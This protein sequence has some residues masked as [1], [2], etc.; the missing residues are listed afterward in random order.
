M[1]VGRGWN[2]A[3]VAIV[4][5]GL[6]GVIALTAELRYG[7]RDTPKVA[8]VAG[9]VLDGYTPFGGVALL[10]IPAGRTWAGTLS[11]EGSL[12]NAGGSA[13]IDAAAIISTTGDGVIPAAGPLL[14]LRLSVANSSAGSPGNQSVG[15]VIQPFTVFATG[16]GPV[17][18][19]TFASN[20]T[21][22][23]FAA[24]GALL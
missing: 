2:R 24:S 19:T 10:T 20:L 3:I 12:R 6:V 7:K 16:H 15:Q 11:I 5:I 14:D 18:L 13:A 22:V 21:Q 17:T 8:P 9:N 23:S 1:R 4:V